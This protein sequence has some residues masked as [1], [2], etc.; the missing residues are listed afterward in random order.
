VKLFKL[1]LLFHS[2]L[3]VARGVEHR[4]MPARCRLHFLSLLAATLRRRRCS[5][6]LVDDV[7][8]HLVGEGNKQGN[9]LV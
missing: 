6:Y 8:F 5:P 2:W 9:F 3:I 7:A 1:D 4:L